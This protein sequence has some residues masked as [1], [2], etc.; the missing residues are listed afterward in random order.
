M[1]RKSNGK[2]ESNDPIY[3]SIV[4]VMFG[5][6][7]STFLHD[8]ILHGIAAKI[9]GWSIDSYDMGGIFGMTGSTSV[10]APVSASWPSLWFYF[11]FPSLAIFILTVIITFLKPE[12]SIMVGGTILMS[13]NL[14][15]LHPTITGSDAY[16]AVNMLLKHGFSEWLVYVA[17]FLLFILVLILWAL[18]LYVIIENNQNDAK[19][20][21]ENIYH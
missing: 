1:N 16:N 8:P 3:W 13:L 4:I 14:P 7:L 18:Y 9:N 5:L 6:S 10:I 15:S 21:V 2:M 19:K 20:R 17:H 12:K 11:M